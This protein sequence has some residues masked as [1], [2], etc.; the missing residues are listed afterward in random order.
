ML[1]EAQSKSEVKGCKNLEADK[2]EHK[3]KQ[4]VDKNFQKL[5]KNYLFTFTL[6]ARPKYHFY[7]SEFSPKAMTDVFLPQQLYQKL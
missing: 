1:N 7:M 6:K 5:D 2:T 3:K 4:I